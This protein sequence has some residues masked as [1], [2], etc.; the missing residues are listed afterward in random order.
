MNYLE[1]RK[2]GESKDLKWA[3]S[4][5]IIIVGGNK[6]AFLIDDK[7]PLYRLNPLSHSLENVDDVPSTSNAVKE[8]LR[9]GKFFQV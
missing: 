5:D 1:G 9:K 6:P 3:E 2:T 4:F 7:M 8:F